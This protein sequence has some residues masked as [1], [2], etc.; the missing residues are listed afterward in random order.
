MTKTT[1]SFQPLATALVLALAC[2]SLARADDAADCRKAD[3]QLLEGKVAAKPAFKHGKFIKGV[4]LSHT[5][6]RLVA[7]SDG[8]AYDVAID[9]VFANGYQKNSKTVPA[10]LN[11]INVGDRIAA[12]GQPFAGGIH[13]VHTNCGDAP[14]TSHP[15]GWIKKVQPD[16]SLGPNLESNQTYCRL[17][18]N[19]R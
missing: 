11:T 4:E 16:G 13:W 9:N 14:S 18:G 15:D 3:G 17:W 19:G 1:T 6:I 12:C 5:H 7:D 10:P 8:K 2:V